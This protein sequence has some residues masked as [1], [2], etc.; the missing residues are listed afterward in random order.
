MEERQHAEHDVAPGDHRRVDGGDLLDVGEQG[1]V[2]EHR[3]ARPARRTAGVEQHRERL[4]VDPHG[5]YGCARRRDQLVPA[6]LARGQ[7]GAD[8][9]D[10]RP[11][12]GLHAHRLQR[13]VEAAD[14]RA[15]RGDGGRVGDHHAGAGVGQHP[16]QLAGDAARVDR[17]DDHAGPQRAEVG[18]D[19][20]DPVASRDHHAV[21]GDHAG[22]GEPLATTRSASASSALQVM[23]ASRR[24]LAQ[25]RLVGLL[26]GRP[27]QRARRR[28]TP[29]E[30]FR[31][32][33]RHEWWCT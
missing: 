24:R 26:L 32:S 14:G 27:G 11:R 29:S 18:G 12:R 6:A 20:L 19:E 7:G 28:W 17:H 5:R 8:G 25:G 9:D 1:P 4:G 31:T 23:R 10:A 15:H 13:L 2:G 30:E 33:G 22:V 3:G 16:D 21:A